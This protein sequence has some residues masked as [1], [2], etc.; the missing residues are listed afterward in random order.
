[1]SGGRHPP[2]PGQASNVATLLSLHMWYLWLLWNLM[3]LQV[4]Q[5]YHHLEV[6]ISTWAF[7]PLKT[8]FIRCEFDDDKRIVQHVTMTRVE[9]CGQKVAPLLLCPVT[10]FVMLHTVFCHTLS[11]H[12]VLSVM[13][14]FCHAVV[15]LLSHFVMSHTV[16]CH[17]LCSVTLLTSRYSN[18]C[19][20]TRHNTLFTEWLTLFCCHAWFFFYFLLCYQELIISCICNLFHHDR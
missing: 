1:M 16:S 9:Q 15:T 3:L 6:L 14:H 7:Q 18:I 11:C 5:A 17:T 12:T 8:A 10:L 13:S 2:W 19:E 4:T 20:D